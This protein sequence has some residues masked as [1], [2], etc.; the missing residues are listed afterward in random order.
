MDEDGEP[1]GTIEWLKKHL[2]R[3]KFSDLPNRKHL[4]PLG[5]HYGDREIA[6]RVIQL[7]T[8]GTQELKKSLLPPLDSERV[9][10]KSTAP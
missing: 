9:M 4:A 1:K 10:E 5:F 2:P 6:E 8:V 3:I 7:L